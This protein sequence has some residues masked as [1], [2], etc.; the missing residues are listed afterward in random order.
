MYLCF[1]KFRTN[2]MMCGCYF[3][4]EESA[5]HNM[6]HKLLLL[7]SQRYGGVINEGKLIFLFT[8][9]VRWY[10]CAHFI[11]LFRKVAAKNRRKFRNTQKVDTHL[12]YIGI[13]I[14]HFYISQLAIQHILFHCSSSFTGYQTAEAYDFHRGFHFHFHFHCVRAPSLLRVFWAFL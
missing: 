11:L 9:V 10:L 6:R 13:K 14:F 12:A 7:S 8:S 4:S 3:D 1:S 5:A 2:P